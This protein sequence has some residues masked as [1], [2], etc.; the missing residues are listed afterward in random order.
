MGEISIG[1]NRV[2]TGMG[3]H[4]FLPCGYH[5]YGYRCQICRP[6]QHCTRHGLPTVSATVPARTCGWLCTASHTHQGKS[7]FLSSPRLLPRAF[8]CPCLLEPPPR[9]CHLE[10]AISRRARP[11]CLPPRR[12]LPRAISR[13]CAISRPARL[14]LHS[15]ELP[16]QDG[17]CP[18]RLPP[19]RPLSQPSLAPCHLSPVR[20]EPATLSEPSQDGPCPAVSCPAVPVHAVSRSTLSSRPTSLEPAISRRPCPCVSHP[21]VP[22]PCYLSL[23]RLSPCAV[24]PCT[25]LSRH[26]KMGPAHAVSRPPSPVPRRLSPRAV[27]RPVQPSSLHLR[28]HLKMGPAHAVSALPSPVHAVS[29]SM[30]SLAPRSLEP[31]ISRRPAHTVSHPTISCPTPPRAHH[32]KI[33]IIK[34]HS[35]VQYKK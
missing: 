15:L 35:L 8:S 3:N 29:R 11:R 25:A 5:G 32:W 26:L 2:T 16:S 22:A 31:A 28:S 7:S 4:G 14:A 9:A 34:L 17:P 18:C 6:R 20:L 21:A 23:R 13:P 10:R 1:N 19:R 33:I 27:S 24:S 12:P 30:L